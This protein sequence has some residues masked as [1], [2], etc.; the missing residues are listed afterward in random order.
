MFLNIIENLSLCKIKNSQI[1]R[2]NKIEY[3][4]FFHNY[5]SNITLV[6]YRYNDCLFLLCFLTKILR[7]SVVNPWK[8]I[9]G[10]FLPVNLAYSL[11]KCVRRDKRSY[12]QGK[13]TRRS[14]MVICVFES[15]VSWI[16]NVLTKLLNEEQSQFSKEEGE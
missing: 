12:L 16:L 1:T 10:T 5:W 13:F 6:S 11:E 15:M 2:N 7:N 3:H 14:L 4:D 9:W 8:A